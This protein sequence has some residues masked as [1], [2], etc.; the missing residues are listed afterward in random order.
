MKVK[1]GKAIF[2]SDEEP[3]MLILSK[4][5]KQQ[6]AHM[7]EQTKYCSFPEGLKTE[8]IVE[9]MKHGTDARTL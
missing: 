5:E 2:D 6:I 3:V 8:E 1:V 7:G 9:F 4:E